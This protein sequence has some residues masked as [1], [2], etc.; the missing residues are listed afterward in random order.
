V[1][2][3]MG[4]LRYAGFIVLVA[5]GSSA[6][7]FLASEHGIGLSGVV[8]A[9]FGLLYALRRDKGFAAEQV[10]PQIVRLFVGWFFLCI[11][12]TYTNIMP[13]GNVA[14]G[15]GAVLGW[16]VGKSLLVRQG[17]AALAA[18]SVL[19]LAMVAATQHMPWN[20]EYAWDRATQYAKQKNY[21][22]ALIW[23][24][25]AARA[26]PNNRELADYVRYLEERGKGLN[27]KEID[28]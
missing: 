15:A 8:Y 4:S 1:E 10:H 12:L 3:W 5:A 20:G 14:H 19:V 21:R 2:A 26:Y 9:L 7:S 27:N 25:K 23:Y 22:E 24:R 18:V 11:L 28:E 16:L 17:I 13:I 6:T